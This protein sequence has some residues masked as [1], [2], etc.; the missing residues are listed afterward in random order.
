M[1][2]LLNLYNAYNTVM[3]AT[4]RIPVSEETWKELGKEKEP[5]QTW[6]ELLEQL[7]VKAMKNQVASKARKAKEGDLDTVD[8]DDI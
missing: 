1:L 8:L 7:R 2:N 6:D 3:S 4:K 5:G